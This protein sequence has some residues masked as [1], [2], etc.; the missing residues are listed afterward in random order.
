MLD[1]VER[2]GLD[3][4]GGLFLESYRYGSHVRTNKHWWLQA[5]TLVGFMNGFELTGQPKYWD[6]VKLSWDFIDK[7]VID[8]TGANG[9]PSQPAGPTFFNRTGG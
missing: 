4:D 2:V 5:E 6:N 3:K 7:Y 1:V 8:T 9:L